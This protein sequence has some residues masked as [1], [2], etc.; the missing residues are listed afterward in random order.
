MCLLIDG[1]KNLNEQT[2]DLDSFFS[3]KS[4][5]VVGASSK[6]GKIGNELVKNLSHYEFKAKVYPINPKADEILGLKCYPSISKVPD[7]IDLAIYVAPSTILPDLVEEAGK[8]GVKN[9]IVVSGGFKEMGDD[10]SANE[11][12]LVSV[13][14]KYGIRI[15]GPNCIGV[16]DGKTRLDTFFYPHDRMIRPKLGGVSFITQSGTFGL[17]FLE[18]A[19][20]SRLGMRRLVSLGNRC[21]VDEIDIINYLGED[22]L[23]KVIAVHLESL[24]DGRRLSE[25]SRKVSTKKPIV[26][27]KAGR[28]EG[29][30][31]A[32]SHTGAITGS[33][34]VCNSILENSGTI[35]ANSFEELFDIIKAIEKQPIAKG[36]KV[37]I[38]TNAAG[39][40]V[41]A[42]DLCNELGLPLGKY[43]DEILNKLS[44]SL[45]QYAVIGEYVDL[46]GS[47]TSEDYQKTFDII[48]SDPN[49]DAIINFIVFLNPPLSPDVV[50]VIAKAQRYGKPIVNW[51][52]GGKFSQGLISKLEETGIPTYSTAERAVLAIK[53][54]IKAGESKKWISTEK[55]VAKKNEVVEVF[56]RVSSEGR[57][58]LTE[59]E[60]KEVLRA[61]GIKTT[62]DHI[63]KTA[64][65]ASSYAE[66]IGFPVVL[67]VIS[68][69]I[70]H[71]SDVGGVVTNV[72]TKQEVVHAFDRIIKNVKDK[73]LDAKIDGMLIQNQIPPGV[74]VLVGSTIDNDFGPVIAFGLGGVLVEAIR[75]V[76]YGLAPLSR[77]DALFMISNT[78]VSELLKGI[79]GQPPADLNKLA[80][81]IMRVSHLAYD[82]SIAEMDLNPVI[83][84]A[85]ECTVADAR[86]RMKT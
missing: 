72:K 6:P 48:F 43:S 54:L 66:K 21:D 4:V 46:T 58:M 83:V 41:A 7:P 31:A 14:H 60:S 78:K 69:D 35:I 77:E 30:K 37:T 53:G 1:V 84:S 25:I 65:E 68:T 75:D 59:S 26:L 33:Y 67:K 64:N 40:S 76:S 85:D 45:P 82:Q 44:S 17:T 38:V 51:A 81:L 15:I 11:A 47:A 20:S 57:D 12:K 22:P 28:V 34:Q 80:D 2:S 32:K 86:I 23:T 8:K 73:V 79:R 13:S 39:P 62:S 5:A 70:T 10:K 16:F 71:K 24:S 50:Q 19:T 61:Y 18:W 27:Y 56:K 3:P 9:A 49:F 63:A 42:A 74:E 36:K 52:T 55:I 29:S